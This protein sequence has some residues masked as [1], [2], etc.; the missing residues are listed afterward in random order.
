MKPE[1]IS[2]DAFCVIGKVGSTEDSPDIVRQLWQEANAHFSE[3]AALAKRDGQGRFAGFWGAMSR[4][5]M[6]FQPWEDHF[7]RGLYLAGVEAEE[8]A[9]APEGWK[10][11][12]VPGFEGR[13]VRAEGPDTFG[14]M[15]AWMEENGCAL[16]AAVQDYTDPATGENYM[17]FP[18]ALNDSKDRLLER[19]KAKTEPLG[20][21]GF[22]CGHCFL[23]QWCGYCRS[24]CNMCSY[25]TLSADN[26]CENEK[27]ANEKGLRGCYDCIELADC[28]K[29]FFGTSDGSIPRAGAFFIRKYGAEEYDRVLTAADG[30]GILMQGDKSTEENLRMLEELREV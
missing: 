18:T 15:L 30:K 8:D 16:A 17:L 13:K 1:K 14:E 24:A 3:V 2:I 25:A 27:C 29:G 12:I 22:H 9:A 21:C 10:K 11:W 28:E 7:S 23:D 6:S 20:F 4:S 26:R 19:I 5:D